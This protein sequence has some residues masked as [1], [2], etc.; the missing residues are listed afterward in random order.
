MLRCHYNISSSKMQAILLYNLL[1]NYNAIPFH[2]IPYGGAT[3]KHLSQN[4]H[5]H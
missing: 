4:P 2:N 3:I 1:W 5:K